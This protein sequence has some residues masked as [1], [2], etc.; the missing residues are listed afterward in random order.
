MIFIDDK[1]ENIKSAV[2]QGFVG[3]HVNPKLDDATF[4]KQLRAAYQSLGLYGK[5]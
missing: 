4:V 5:K 3:I 2:A 1:L